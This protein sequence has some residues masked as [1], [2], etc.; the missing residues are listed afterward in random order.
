MIGSAKLFCSNKS[1]PSLLSFQSSVLAAHPSQLSHGHPSKNFSCKRKKELHHH[2]QVK[3]NALWKN[4][5]LDKVDHKGI[6]S[7][8]LP[9]LGCIHRYICSQCH[10]YSDIPIIEQQVFLY[11]LQKLWREI[12]TDR[13]KLTLEASGKLGSLQ[14][15]PQ[16]QLSQPEQPLRHLL[17]QGHSE[18]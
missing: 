12:Q 6:F 3:L 15:F 5:Y 4:W 1:W 11:T 7:P 16:V 8:F 2:R 18:R 17:W 14:A 10:N 9:F 13:G